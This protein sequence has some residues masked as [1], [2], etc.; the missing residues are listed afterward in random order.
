VE[1]VAMMVRLGLAAAAVVVFSAQASATTDGE[2]RAVLEKRFAGDRTGAC[3]AA[4]VVEQGRTSTAYFCADPK[5]ARPYDGR[6]AFEIGSVTKTMTAA[7]LADLIV[8]GEVTLDDP[9]AKL[10]PAG[11]KVATFNGEPILLKHVVTHTSGLAALP[12]RMTVTDMRNPYAHLTEQELLQS[13]AEA[14]LASKPGTKFVYSNFAMMVLSYALAKRSG[15]D[16]ETL[17]HE[18][19][20]AP[21]GIK[22]AYIAKPPAGVRA[23][24]GHM[25]TGAPTSAWDIPVNMAGVGGVRAT[26]PDMIAYVRAQ[27]RP[28]G[29]A[30]GRAIALTQ[31]QVIEVP[32]ARVGMNWLLAP[33]A[34]RM[35]LQ[36]EG[37]TGGFSALVIVDKQAGRA[38]V[39]LSDAAQTDLGGLG[40]VGLHLID[41]GQPIGS[42]RKVAVADGVLL[43]A[44]VGRYRLDTGLG[45]VL[46]RKGMSL[47]IQADAQPEFEM[48]F[49]SAGDF[50]PMQFDALLRPV[51]KADGSYTFT[52]HQLGGMMKAERLGAPAAT[53]PSFR[54][55]AEELKGYEGLYP[56]TADFALKVFADG[57]KLYVQG[58][59]QG[60]I[61]IVPVAKDVFVADS[62]GAEINFERDA[63][64]KVAAL[65]LK[66]GGQVLRGVKR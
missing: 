10:L 22:D 66:Q 49:D 32:G 55:S 31:N 5:T 9:L 26:L 24:Q 53:G 52:W 41:P 44:L 33:V 12:S 56:L 16:F 11:T 59:G 62:V 61:E 36:H 39:V 46:R 25:T 6:T 38:V 58:T 17:L 14:K 4:A 64:G 2:L 23:A 30:T 47:T 45:M 7:L 18:K 51:R 65:V 50:Y 13:L 37:G 29:D 8:K 60:P 20:F 21:L 43:D 35:T 57:A 19:L 1:E 28:G 63:G 15:K 48:G 40:T 54:P 34:G 27:L 42:P 3:V